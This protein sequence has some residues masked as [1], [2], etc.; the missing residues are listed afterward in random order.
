MNIYI[1]GYISAV[2]KL[3]ASLAPL[4]SRYIDK[5]NWYMHEQLITWEEKAMSY[6]YCN[7]YDNI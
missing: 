2:K 6:F 3:R 1:D 5:V 4:Q 7:Y